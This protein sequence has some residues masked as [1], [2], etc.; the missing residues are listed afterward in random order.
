VSEPDLKQPTDLDPTTDSENLDRVG[1]PFALVQIRWMRLHRSVRKFEHQRT[2]GRG[3]AQHVVFID[4][5]RTLN[6]VLFG[7]AAPY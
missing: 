6:C 2:I 3:V 4:V 7:V 5:N 1:R